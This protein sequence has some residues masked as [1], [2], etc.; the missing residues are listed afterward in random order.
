MAIGFGDSPEKPLLLSIELHKALSKYN[1]SK[2][3]KEK[4]LLRI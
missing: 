4:L 2:R 3:G 1:E